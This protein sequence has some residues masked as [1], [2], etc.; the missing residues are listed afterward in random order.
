VSTKPFPSKNRMS[1]ENVYECRVIVDWVQMRYDRR[2][3]CQVWP[4]SW[5]WFT[6]L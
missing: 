4:P 6:L 1:S 5:K 2:K 3:R